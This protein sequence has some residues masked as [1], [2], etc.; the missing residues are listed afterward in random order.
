MIQA[1]AK[2]Y[3]DLTRYNLGFSIVIG[4][5]TFRPIIGVGIFATVG[6]LFGLV[7][8]RHYQNNQ[9]YFYYNLGI[10]K[11]KLILI[12]WVINGFVTAFLFTIML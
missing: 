2:Y 12:T 5:F 8:Y 3:F 6:M 4:L 9:Y 10:S 7:C 1:I 11:F